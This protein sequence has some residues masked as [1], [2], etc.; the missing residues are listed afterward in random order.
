MLKKTRNKTLKQ[1]R[2]HQ[3][4]ISNRPLL[5][6]IIPFTR[7]R[8][9]PSRSFDLSHFIFF[10]MAIGIPHSS[11]RELNGYVFTAMFGEEKKKE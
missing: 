11:V 3:T 8:H 10:F 9:A 2:Y 6:I 5:S 7:E 1:D 4:T